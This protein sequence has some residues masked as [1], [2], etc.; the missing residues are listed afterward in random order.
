MARDGVRSKAWWFIAL[1]VVL[2]YSAGPLAHLLENVVQVSP[3]GTVSLDVSENSQAA[4]FTFR[5]AGGSIDGALGSLNEVADE[6][7]G[8]AIAQRLTDL[9]GGSLSVTRESGDAVF[10]LCIP[11]VN[12]AT[13][14]S[15]LMH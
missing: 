12:E 8:L 9:L 15:D 10:K 1:G 3:D 11:I 2:I 6:G 13:R 4:E 14:P 5:N 7:L